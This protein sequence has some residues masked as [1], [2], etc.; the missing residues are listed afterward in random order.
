VIPAALILDFEIVEGAGG[1]IYDGSIYFDGIGVNSED[2]FYDSSFHWARFD[3]LIYGLAADLATLET[4]RA[5]VET[6]ID[7]YKPVRCVLHDLLFIEYI[8]VGS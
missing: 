1:Y 5:V 2:V 7:H 8:Q 4:Y 6:M 3:V